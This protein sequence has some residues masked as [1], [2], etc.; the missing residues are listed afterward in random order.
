MNREAELK[1]PS[2]VS[3]SDLLGILAITRI[4]HS[5]YRVRKMMCIH[6]DNLE[7]YRITSLNFGGGASRIGKRKSH[8][9]IF[10][11]PSSGV[12]VGLGRSPLFD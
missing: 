7:I 6:T 9:R 8:N 3:C 1:P 10:N 4:R 5:V 11:L 2:R 12:V